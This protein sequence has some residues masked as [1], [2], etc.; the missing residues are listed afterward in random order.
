MARAQQSRYFPVRRNGTTLRLPLYDSYRLE[1][2]DR[3]SN[4]SPAPGRLKT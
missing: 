2:P 3:A 1:G 4:Q